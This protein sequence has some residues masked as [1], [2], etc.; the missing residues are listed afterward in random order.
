MENLTL[1]DAY[2]LLHS[3]KTVLVVEDDKDVSALLSWALRDQ[4][5][6]V[7][8][9]AD[10]VEALALVCEQDPDLILLDMMMPKMNG[11]QFVQEFRRRFRSSLTPIIV[12]SATC[13]LQSH[14]SRL[15]L[16]H[17][18]RK[19]FDLREL[20]RLTRQCCPASVV[21]QS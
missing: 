18:L 15:N 12:M 21:T 20:F 7:L 14:A 5:Y 3:Y 19:P 9:A 16:Q 6:R 4:G 1:Q 11:W 13:D 10:G 17:Y 2:R 8:T